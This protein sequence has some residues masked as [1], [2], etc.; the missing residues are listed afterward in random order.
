MVIPALRIALGF[1]GG[2]GFL[3]AATA[4]LGAFLF[5]TNTIKHNAAKT[6]VAA[7]IEKA[8]SDAKAAE[9]KTEQVRVDAARPGAVDRLRRD[10]KSC[11]DCQPERHGK[12]VQKLA[13]S[14]DQKR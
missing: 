9:V 2:N 6:A 8:N 4:A 10:P 5:Y 11:P 14:N 1:F 3:L 13:T 7:V 12:P